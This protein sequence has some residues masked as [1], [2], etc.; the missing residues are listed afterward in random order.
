MSRIPGWR[1]VEE[2]ALAHGYADRSTTNRHLKQGYCAWPRPVKKRFGDPAP[3]DGRTDHP[4]YHRW[5]NMR[6]KC[7]NPDF[8]DY[9]YYGG[10]G[11][12]MSEVW[13][14][15]FWAFVADVERLPGYDPALTLD[16]INNDGPYELGNVRWVTRLVQ[17]S[18][19]RPK[20]NRYG[21][22]GLSPDKGIWR[23]RVKGQPCRWFKTLE[24]AVEHL[25]SC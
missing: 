19:Q 18:N 11:I 7:L 4:L 20:K 5:A 21:V 10:R 15:D 16:R 6:H 2:F 3:A 17:S 23:Y 13:Q 24:S 1:S 25:L 14:K 9:A 12:R 22:P 8:P